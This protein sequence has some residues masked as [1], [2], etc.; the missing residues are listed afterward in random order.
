MM[1]QMRKN[2]KWIML[3]TALAF[4]ALMVFEWGMDASG[5]SGGGV[6]SIGTVNG[7]AVPNDQYQNTR[8]NLYSQLQQSQEGSVTSAQDR[9]LD[10]TAWDETVNQILIGQELVRRGI[11]VTD[12]EVRQAAQ[13]SPPPAFRNSPVFQ[14]D[15]QFDMQKYQQY[16]STAD[17][18]TLLELEA[19][20]RDVIPRGKLLRQVSTGLYVPDAE[21]WR[22]YRDQ[23]E[24]VSVR[25]VTL[26]P[27]TRIADSL[28]MPSEAELKAYYED[29]IEDYAVPARASIRVMAVPKTLTAADTL[30]AEERINSVRQAIADGEDFADVAL[31]ESSDQGSAERGGDL[32]WFPRGRM[33]PAFDSAVFAAPIGRPT[34]PFR[35]QFGWH[36]L[37]VLERAG[38]SASAR[39]ILVPI[40]LTE[41]SEIAQLTL[42]DS[43]EALL[44]NVSFD[45]TARILDLPIQTLDV[46]QEFPFV[47]GAGQISEGADWAIEEAEIREISDV[48]E[49]DQAYYAVEVL[50]VTEA[51]TL[52]L[53]QA[54]QSIEQI[55]LR[56]K[57]LELAA[58]QARATVA[59]SG[60]SLD[61]IATALGTTVRT[62]DAFARGG[63]APGLG[64][65]NAAIGTAFGLE[66]G[67]VSD[68]ILTNTDG[69]YL[70][71]VE[72]I[73]ADSAAW[74]AQ[75]EIQRLQ[76]QSVMGQNRLQLWLEG[77]RETARIV[78]RRDEVLL[79]PGEEAPRGGLFGVGL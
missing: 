32:G 19:Y 12:D 77:L 63:F 47:Q 1:R 27:G 74:E 51:N 78:D 10:E 18:A 20:Y 16:L 7:T 60:G 36:V 67:K 79:Q 57:K 48:F 46:T 43:L 66:L 33:T 73:P 13:F 24:Q 75:K 69:V 8:S 38:D 22:A 28:A 54:R 26:E 14:T 70:E 49:N 5:Q 31:R 45:E 61:A 37:E 59:S 21:L 56:K 34:Q 62:S 3:L 6:G 64:S 72:R 42:A 2:T 17:E 68:L 44:E 58:E 11:T 39:H 52:T 71:V 25:F 4:F 30:A 50:N 35:S 9:E 55:L 53:E 23:N 40:E 15:G 29:H 76:R 41:E 65:Q